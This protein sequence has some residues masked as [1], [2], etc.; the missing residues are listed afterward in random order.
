MLLLLCIGSSE[1][2]VC[3]LSFTSSLPINPKDAPVADSDHIRWPGGA[4]AALLAGQCGSIAC[5]DSLCG[6]VAKSQERRFQ[7]GVWARVTPSGQNTP[8]CHKCFNNSSTPGPFMPEVSLGEQLPE[9][10]LLPSAPGPPEVKFTRR[11][12]LHP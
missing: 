3:S 2:C 12:T 9:T 10:T 7:N 4:T 6:Y 8:S 5:A 11:L 1:P